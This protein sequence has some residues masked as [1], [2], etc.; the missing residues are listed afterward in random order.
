MILFSRNEVKN[1][2]I[3][4]FIISIYYF[5]N[6]LLKINLFISEK[7]LQFFPERD[8][9]SFLLLLSFLFYSIYLKY[10]D[11]KKG[12]RPSHDY[13][14]ICAI[15]S[16]LYFIWSRLTS[17]YDFYVITNYLPFIYYSDIF[18]LGVIIYFSDFKYSSIL[19][20]NYN[21]WFLFDND[22]TENKNDRINNENYV[23]HLINAI[24]H[25]HGKGSFTIG[26]QGSWGSGKTDFLKRLINQLK[27][28][29][30]NIVIEFNPWRASMSG[31]SSILNDFFKT[32]GQEL[33]KYNKKSSKK[34]LTYFHNLLGV[35]KEFPL[36]VSQ[37]MLSQLAQEK[38]TSE[39]LKEINSIIDRIGKRLLISIDDIDR[40]SGEEI[41]TI[42]TLVRNVAYFNNTFYLIPFDN[43]Y[44]QRA[45]EKT[46]KFPKADQYINKIIQLS[47]TIPQIRKADLADYI[48]EVVQNDQ[49]LSEIE[50]EQMAKAIKLFSKELTFESFSIEDHH[51]EYLLDNY[52]DAKR[53]YN[54]FRIIYSAL[55][56]K[57]HTN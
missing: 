28:K 3:S 53:F 17:N 23:A 44:V 4:I 8:P 34:L 10:L 6:E 52:R 12:L 9:L 50:K 16:L 41:V 2:R 25:S 24:E 56:W 1:I 29:D 39:S 19:N 15:L 37:L 49:S 46:D 31:S 30:E 22:Q 35:S 55:K 40:M 14:V 47:I 32:I 42:F 45:I 51:F 48:V 20:T 5:A 43:E 21:S 27:S 33:D 13:L 57:I 26:I 36:A 54:S 38:S 18:L 7:W 11:F